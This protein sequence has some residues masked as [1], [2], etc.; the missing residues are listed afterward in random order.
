MTSQERSEPADRRCGTCKR[1]RPK[2]ER[3]RLGDRHYGSC[4]APEPVLAS[5]FGRFIRYDTSSLAGD[6]CSKWLA[7]GKHGD[8]K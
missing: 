7:G 8:L 5:C 3:D 6:N 2:P 4:N 1:W